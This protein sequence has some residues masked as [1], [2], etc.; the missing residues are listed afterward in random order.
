MSGMHSV[1]FYLVVI[2]RMNALRQTSVSPKCTTLSSGYYC[3]PQAMCGHTL[4]RKKQK[5]VQRE[6]LNFLEPFFGEA[7]VHLRCK[8]FSKGSVMFRCGDSGGHERHLNCSCCSWIHLPV[9]T[10]ALSSWNM[11]TS[12]MKSTCTMGCT[13]KNCLISLRH[14]SNMQRNHWTSDSRKI[15]T[16]I[17]VVHLK[18]FLHV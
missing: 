16:H 4:G 10:G 14:Y 3:S 11:E 9:W 6:V 17:S 8:C 15:A 13:C 18:I 2:G 1:S 7:S 5:S 12:W